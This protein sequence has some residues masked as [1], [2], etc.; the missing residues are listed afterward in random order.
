MA[1]IPNPPPPASVPCENSPRRA[2][3]F[4]R[5]GNN[6]R[7]AEMKTGMLNILYQNPFCGHDHEDPYTHLIKFYEIAGLAGVA[8]AEEL[9]LYKRL[10]PHSLVGKAKDWYLDQPTQTMTDWNVL[11]EKFLERFFPNSRK[12]EARTAISMF[13]QG[14]NESLNEAWERFKSMIRKCPSHGFDDQTQIHIFINGLVPSSK[15]LLDATAGGS[16]M[17]KAHEEAVEII[18]KMVRN[19]HKV[20]HDRSNVQRKPRMLELGTNDAILA[21]NKLLSQQVEELTKQMARLPQ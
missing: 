15:L 4:A 21:Q 10:F 19:D 7:Q 2:A 20:Q 11:E 16:L 5:S 9:P 6:A 1:G 17:A 12:M 3:Q 13:S 14:G 18:E 8:E